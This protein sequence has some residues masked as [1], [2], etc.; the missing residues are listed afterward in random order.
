MKKETTAMDIFFKILGY[1]AAASTTIAFV[2]QMI[3]V[4]KTRDTRS[5]SL[6]M[7][8]IFIFG[9]ICWL[10]YGIYKVDW[11]II[12]ANAVSAVFSSIILVFK[13]INVVHGEKPIN[14]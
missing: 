7:Y 10:T 3:S 11:P 9:I 12:I 6:G 1:I 2:P 8:I 14:M 5:I 13:I 4:V